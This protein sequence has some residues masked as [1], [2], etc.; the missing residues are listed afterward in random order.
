MINWWCKKNIIALLGLLVTVI[1][2]MFDRNMDVLVKCHNFHL[3]LVG[4][5]EQKL[6]CG[7]MF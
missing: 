2:G 6:D 3:S 7:Q 5:G 1:D 4:G